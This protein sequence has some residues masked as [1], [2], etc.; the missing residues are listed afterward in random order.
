MLSL[1]IVDIQLTWIHKIS[2]WAYCLF[3]YY[4]FLFRAPPVTCGSSQARGWIRAVAAGLHYSY[5]SMRYKLHLWPTTSSWQRRILNLLSKARDWTSI[6]L[7]TSQDR[8]HWG[9]MATPKLTAFFE[10]RFLSCLLLKFLSEWSAAPNLA[11]PV[12]WMSAF[13]PELCS[14]SRW[15]VIL[16]VPLQCPAQHLMQID[17]E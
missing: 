11:S 17:S 6:L 7:D 15:A 4:F 3:I 5:S 9:T 16:F 1:L 14:S 10:H 2:L 12:W 8:Y 13:A